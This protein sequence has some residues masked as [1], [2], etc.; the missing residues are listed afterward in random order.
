MSS[1]TLQ[2][3][4]SRRSVR[5][6]KPEQ[7][8]PALL[9]QVLEAGTYAPTASG[10][11]AVII[12]AAQD[13]ETVG[14]LSRLNAAVMG[15][16]DGDPFYGAPTVL[17]VLADASYATYQLSGAAV[18]TNLVNAAHAVGLGSCWIHRAKEELE[19]EEGKAL[20]KRWGIPDGYVGVGHCVLGYA[21]ETPEAAPRKADYIRRV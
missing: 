18:L 19:S 6:Y 12:V 20:C 7:I 4:K 13:P 14:T 2:N 10:R 5:A 21:A 15:R 17:V 1:E 9:E 8:D 3:L 11:Q 16:D